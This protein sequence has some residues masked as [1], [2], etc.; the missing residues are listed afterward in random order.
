MGIGIAHSK[1]GVV[2]TQRKYVLDILKETGLLDCK[3]IDTPMDPNLKLL[4]G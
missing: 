1:S 2:M 3:P 4:P